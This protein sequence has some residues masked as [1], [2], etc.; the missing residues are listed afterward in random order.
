MDFELLKLLKD[1]GCRYVLW[2]LEGASEK[3]IKVYRKQYAPEKA[4]EI[5]KKSSEL[6]IVNDVGFIYNGPGED[7]KDVE[8][9]IDF[10]KKFIFDDNVIMTFNDFYLEENSIVDRKPKK[11]GIKIL[12]RPQKDKF[13]FRERILFAEDGL[14]LNELNAKKEKHSE[15]IDRLKSKILAAKIINKINKKIGFILV[16]RIELSIILIQLLKKILKK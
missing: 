2:G 16:P 9:I 11:F 10:A 4:Y 3:M 5:I 12:S 1:S 6:G 15:L 13:V 7:E 8:A 14:S